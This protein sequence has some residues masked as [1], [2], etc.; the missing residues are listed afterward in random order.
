LGESEER[1]VTL[2]YPIALGRTG[3]IGRPTSFPILPVGGAAFVGAFDAI[4]NLVHVWCIAR[5]WLSSYTGR[6]VRFR[7]SSDNAELDFTYDADGNLDVAAVAAWAG[8]SA[9]VVVVADQVSADDVSQGTA[10]NQP[11]FVASG[12][13]GHAVGRGGGALGNRFLVATFSAALSQ[14]F[15]VYTA[16]KASG[17]AS[18][19]QWLLSDLA[20][21]DNLY[22]AMFSSLFRFYANSNLLSGTANTNWNIW[23][24]LANGVSGEF[25]ING[26]SQQAGNAGAFNP[27]GITIGASAGGTSGWIGDIATIA[28]AENHDTTARQAVEAALDDYWSIV[29]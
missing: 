21:S 29:P 12:Q 2:I 6:L 11:L 10:G 20:P 7:R 8:G 13:N 9:F 27:A 24:G 14:P 28:I 5:R 15:N 25:W 17:L 16:A 4:A 26:V 22:F 1:P 23:T 19:T 18:T 3:M